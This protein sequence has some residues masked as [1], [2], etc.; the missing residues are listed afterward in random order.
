MHQAGVSGRDIAAVGF[1]SAMHS[2]IAVEA[3]GLP[4]TNSI[5]WVDIHSA[6][7]TERLKQDG[8][9]H[10]LFLRTRTPI[11]PIS[12]LTKLMWMREAAH[13]G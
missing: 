2:L 3:Q 12:P 8:T 5:V 9:G 13:L 6:T 1:N 7:Q 4:L 11:H 10:A